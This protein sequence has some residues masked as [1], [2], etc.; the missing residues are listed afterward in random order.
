M[1]DG[2]SPPIGHA[3]TRKSRENALGG[4]DLIREAGAALEVTPNPSFGIVQEP[5]RNDWG[6]DGGNS[7]RGSGVR[8]AQVSLRVIK[9]A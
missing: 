5:R 7:T 8:F 9:H 2:V 4:S 1:G 3:G 6:P